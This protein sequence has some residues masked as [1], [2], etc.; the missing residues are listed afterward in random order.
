MAKGKYAKFP[1]APEG[2]TIEY[3][4][5][6]AVAWYPRGERKVV[7]LGGEPL[8]WEVLTASHARELAC[9]IGAFVEA[10]ALSKL[11]LADAEHLYRYA[12]AVDAMTRK[13]VGD[14]N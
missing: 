11:W 3:L 7:K 8:P 6:R 10:E 4:E 1:N 13:E 2:S 5:G 14:A 9:E 12:D